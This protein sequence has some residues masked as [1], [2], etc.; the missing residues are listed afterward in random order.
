[1]PI[2]IKPKIDLGPCVLTLKSIEGITELV[3]KEF[4]N[5]TFSANDYIWEIFDEKRAAFIQEIPQREKLDEF[6]VSV[7]LSGAIPVSKKL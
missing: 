5:A 4:P 1:M 3:S 6:I 2:R 7:K